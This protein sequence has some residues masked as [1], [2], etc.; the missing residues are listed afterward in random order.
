MAEAESQRSPAQLDPVLVLSGGG[1]L[2]AAQVGLLR[3][4]YR[5]GF[6][7]AAIVGT[8]VGAIN[9]AFLAFHEEAE[10]LELL[11]EAWL[12][13]G[14]REIFNTNPFRL[15]RNFLSQRNCFFDNGVLRRLLKRYLPVNDFA[16]LHV[17][18]YAVATNLSR[19]TKAVFHQ[20]SLYPAILASA[21][22]PGV[23][24]PIRIEGD[25]YVDGGVLAGLDLATAVELGSRNILAVDVSLCEAGSIPWDVFHIWRR[26]N[27]LTM[28]EQ[29]QRDRQRFA[30]QANIAYVCPPHHLD[31]SP[32][33][34]AHTAALMD[35]AEAFGERMAALLL[36][37]SGR[38]REPTPPHGL[39]A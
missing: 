2:G 8:S 20:G 28:R 17:P 13:I 30:G 27:D 29:V 36:D 16:Q 7:P 37:G 9:G 10:A 12:S 6:R 1:S 3:P 14:A 25:V 32:Q 24:C 19:G 33:D 5:A 31:I 23:L 35:E 26:C 34:F 18:F 15:V 11:R 39:A 21:A 4:F 22:I 38:L